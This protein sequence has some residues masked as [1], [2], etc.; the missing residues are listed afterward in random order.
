MTGRPLYHSFAWAYDL[1]VASP[2]G[3]AP[4]AM[5][6][7]LRGRV[8]TGALV[9]DAGCGSG[10]YAAELAAT[11][12][13]VTGVDR[14]PELIAVAEARGARARFEVGDLREW[15]PSEAFD[16]AVC[17]GV[18]NDLITDE[19]RS[20]AVAGLQRALRPGGVLVVDVRD[21][22]AS[23]E[24]YE[25]RPWFERVVETPRG[26]LEFRSQ[27]VLERS[28]HT[29]LIHERI[30][31]GNEGVGFDFAMRCWTAAELEAA[32][33]AA[34]FNAVEIPARDPDL[35]A[36]RADRIVALALS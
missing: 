13:R 35:Q 8:G 21:W 31:L 11:G 28:A 24:R 16:A 19:D 10:R 15:A 34:G 12:F 9:L 32:L 7:A 22:E 20:A 29:L 33:R 4:H 2:G 18:L 1:V 17:R 36:A 26:R 6:R 3:P 27:T 5:A 25:Q 30:R 23:V 14:S